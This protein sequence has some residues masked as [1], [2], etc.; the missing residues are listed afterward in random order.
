MKRLITHI[1]TILVLC[2]SAVAQD[3]E[4]GKV[5]GAVVDART[6]EPLAGVNVE[7]K[8]TY[9]GAA[10]D[11]DGQFLIT[12][13]SPGQYDIEISIIGY[14]IYLKTG[15][16]VFPGETEI[17]EVELEESIL[18]FGEEIEVIGKKPLLE[19][20]LTSSEESFSSAEI[21]Q[22]IVES[23]DDIV[24]QQAGVVKSDGEI[25]IRGGRADESMYI[26]DGVS[27]KDPLSGYGN[28]VYV[29]PD[30]IKELKVVTG[31]FNA[32]YGQ[33]MSGVIDVV[34]KEGDET[35]SGSFKIK[36]DHLGIGA[37]SNA[38]TQIMEFNLGGP[39]LLTNYIFPVFGLNLPGKF[40][41]FISGY[42]N[43][44]DT[45]LNQASRL[46]PSRASLDAFAPRQENNW[47]VLGKL[48]WRIN[49]AQKISLSYDRSLGINQGFF[50][51]YLISSAYYPYTFSQNLENYPTFTTEAILVN[52][53][54]KHT[55]NQRTFYEVT[56]SDFY[57]STHSAVQNKHWSDYSQRLDLYPIRY[58]P[59]S[60]GNLIVRRGDG[61]YDH[62]D[63][64]QWYDYYSDRWSVKT[65]LTS[66]ITNNQQ[67]K[68]GFELAYTEMQ[69]VDIVD[70][71]VDTGIGFGSSY[72]I[73]KVY[74]Y[75]GYFYVQDQIKYD[76]MIVNIGLRYD[77]WFPGKFVQDAIDDPETV[78]I[79]DEARRLFYEETFGVFGLRGKGQISPRIGISHPVSDQDVLYFHYGHFSQFPNGQFV[80]AKLKATSPATYQQFGNPNLNPQTTVAYELGLKHKF[81]ENLVMD[82]K[83]YYRDIFDYP[84]SERVQ[85]ENPRLGSI[86]YYMYFNGDYA[87]SKG[88]ELRVKQRY[89]KYLTGTLNLTYAVS[90]GK[91]SN[92]T[93][94][95]LVASGKLD[96]KPLKES[97]LSWDRP[98]RL[99]LDLNFQVGDELITLLGLPLPNKWGASL[100]W[101]LE[102]G[103][104]YTQLIDIDQEIYDSAN[105]Y[106]KM[107][108]YWN[109]LDL[110]IYKYIDIMGMNLSLI[111]EM[112]NV[113]DAQIPRI[114]NP[115]TG[116]EYRPGDLLTSS[117]TRD[118]N[119]TPNPIYNPSKYR[120]PRRLR[121]GL[122]LRF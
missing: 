8:G 95:L 109:Q 51:R 20:D 65:E 84:S 119:P 75:L 115:Y 91:A 63:Y 22:K 116:R 32:E 21:E 14:K 2:I 99:T 80:Y 28:T 69:V 29:N 57:N 64:G 71:W 27:V 4:K 120:W 25:H 23:L 117:Y 30:A 90:K 47:H 93:D 38:N 34:T 70:P 121:F 88:V 97:Y 37:F 106:A 13:V 56:I 26:I 58:F 9:M 107:A 122:A 41:F 98:I 59:D 52:F 78:I 104:R 5:A 16:E 83:T 3:I 43:I 18:A 46:Y 54:W 111:V 19:V 67:F 102:S 1:L 53:I 55:L 87:R 61:F 79:S 39:E 45:Y 114:I 108:A 77:Y 105:P 24:A 76:G 36:S 48:S 118:I 6:G 7:V 50:T 92:P 42:G 49:P 85:M 73:Y 94:N 62:G 86:S 60:Q 113:L 110:R 96:Q 17:I 66:Q 68:A 72:D 40:S 89:A 10:T 33:M 31:G 11:L 103:R 100:R 44:S 101:E 35:F 12:N 112:E 15:V 81:N 74:S 82:L